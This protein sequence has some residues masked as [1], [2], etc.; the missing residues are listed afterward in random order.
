VNVREQTLSRALSRGSEGRE[1]K[2]VQEWLG[3]HGVGVKIDGE[4]GP[5]T[6]AA[7]RAFQRSGG[8]VES[9]Q[10]DAATYAALVSPMLR[11]A[12][13]LP[14]QG[15]GLG[16]LALAYARQ[17]LTERPRE[18][19][20][21]NCGPWVRLYMDGNEGASWPWCAGFACFCLEQ[22]AETLGVAL[23][24]TPS[25]SCDSL[26]ASAKQQGRFLPPP[27]PA[28]RTRIGPGSLFLSRRTSTDWVHTGIV[29]SV[30]GDYF[31]T[32]EGNTNDEGSREGY[33]V[34]ARIRG[35][36][37]MDFVLI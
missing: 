10:V 1:V 33:E 14:L 28:D 15:R 26:A 22:A 29:V 21:Q 18:I 34:C 37:A 19:G 4:F 24:I 6:E 8:V 11:A 7:V 13:P 25:F 9:G 20:G 36:G 3:L 31:R 23:P 12:T 35:F 32:I 27:G 2:Q 30:E 17:H 5:A 16:E